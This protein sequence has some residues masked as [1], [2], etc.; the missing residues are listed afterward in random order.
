MPTKVGVVFADTKSKSQGEVR[1][2]RKDGDEFVVKPILKK[3]SPLDVE[4]VSLGLSVEEIVSAIR[5]SRERP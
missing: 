5:E 4:G 2:K 1:I 3:I